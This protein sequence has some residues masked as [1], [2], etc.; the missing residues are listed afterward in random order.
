[1]YTYPCAHGTHGINRCREELFRLSSLRARVSSLGPHSQTLT[2]THSHTDM[3]TH[4]YSHT[5]THTHIIAHTHRAKY[6]LFIFFS[7]PGA[8]SRVHDDG[9]CYYRKYIHV[10]V[11]FFYYYYYFRPIPGYDVRFEEEKK[12]LRY[13]RVYLLFFTI[14]TYEKIIHV[15]TRIAG[16]L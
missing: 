15:V 8:V 11:Y 9:Y 16:E 10:Y 7:H 2:H 14:I 13:N 4:E 12:T 6:L 3:H 5:Y 1:M